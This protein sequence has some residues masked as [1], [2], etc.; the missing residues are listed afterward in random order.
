MF[1]NS[2]R[3]AVLSLFVMLVCTSP[4]LDSPDKLDTDTTSAGTV[5]QSVTGTWTYRVSIMKKP[6]ELIDGMPNI[7][8]SQHYIL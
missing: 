7:F 8:G 5:S 4:D 3:V 2:V 6:S 1:R